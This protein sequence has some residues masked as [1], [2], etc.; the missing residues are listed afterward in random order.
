MKSPSGLDVV[1]FKY[2]DEKY[3]RECFYKLP[4]EPI[5]FSTIRRAVIVQSCIKNCCKCGK[6]LI[7]EGANGQS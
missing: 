1:G 7:K 6:D 5:K 3:C 2:N 4:P